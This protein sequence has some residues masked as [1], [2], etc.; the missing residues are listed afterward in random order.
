[1]KIA[2]T[3][4]AGFIGGHV[5]DELH[6]R[7]HEPVIFDHRAKHHTFPDEPLAYLP[8]MMGDTRDEVQVTELA[9]HVEGIIHLASVLGTQETVRN[10]RPAVMTNVISGMNVFEAAVQ[11]GIP[12]VNI[13]VGNAGMSNP[14][15]ASKTC[16][17]TLGHMYV[18]DRGAR[19]NQVR[20]VNAYGPRQLMAA[21]YGVGKVRKIMP[22]FVARA[23]TGAPI[24]I[25]GDGEQVSD[26]VFVT[27]VAAALV[28]AL[29]FA[30]EGTVLDHVIEVGPSEHRTVNE[31]ADLVRKAA[32]DLAGVE[33]P[34]LVHL[35]MRP[36]ETPGARIIARNDTMHD[37]GMP[38]EYLIP[39][40]TG[41]GE[42]VAWYAEHWLPDY[43]A[44][45]ELGDKYR[46]RDK[47]RG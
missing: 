21:P 44:R 17:E 37:I 40:E 28:N 11:Y 47:I 18:R 24:E 46:P 32:L 5:V 14:Y 26:C 38:P 8:S 29:E 39:L 25:Y 27:D 45:V 34:E 43:R 20:V 33:Q 42:T 35:P 30:A 31:V 23:L 13:C 4:G 15:S 9:A 36:G 19:L 6:R 41:I 10:P 1:M 22:A 7:G 16:V 12:A 3:G 2:V